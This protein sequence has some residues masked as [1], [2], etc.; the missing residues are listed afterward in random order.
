[1]EV[2]RTLMDIME[3]WVC[4]AVVVEALETLAALPEKLAV[5]CRDLGKPQREHLT[6]LLIEA[7]A[8][9]AAQRAAQQ[10]EP[11][12][13]ERQEISPECLAAVVAGLVAA[14]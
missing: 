13:Q 2:L 6:P 3:F 12:L 4:A 8:L 7:M 5:H 1:M 9:L 14:A 10:A 11:E